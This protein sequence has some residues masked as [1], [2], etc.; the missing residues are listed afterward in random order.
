[1]RLNLEPIEPALSDARERLKSRE[2]NDAAVHRALRAAR[3]FLELHRE[4][5]PEEYDLHP[6]LAEVHAGYPYVHVDNSRSV[7][8]CRGDR[9]QVGAAIRAAIQS[10]EFE[11]DTALRLSIELDG[12]V[13]L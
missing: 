11:A 2:T 9:E 8:Q 5:Q 7:R 1:M 13:P 3:D 10:M 6:L 12:E 4:T